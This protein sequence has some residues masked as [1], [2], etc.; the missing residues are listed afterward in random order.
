MEEKRAPHH[1]MNQAKVNQTITA[2]VKIQ[3]LKFD[4]LIFLAPVISKYFHSEIWL[5][6]Q[7]GC[8]LDIYAFLLHIFFFSIAAAPCPT[9]LDKGVPNKGAKR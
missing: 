7:V 6:T 4:T 2:G 3:F 9:H 8:R 1:K 5:Q